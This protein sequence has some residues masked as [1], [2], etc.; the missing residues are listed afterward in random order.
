VL[1]YQ[2]L[3]DEV[4]GRLPEAIDGQKKAIMI[5][6]LLARSYTSLGAQL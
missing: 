5:D 6:P 3:L 4:V 2:S 1:R